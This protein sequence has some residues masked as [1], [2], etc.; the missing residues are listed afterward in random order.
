VE[1]SGERSSI[2]WYSVDSAGNL[3]TTRAS[4]VDSAGTILTTR[5]SLEIYSA[6]HR[7]YFQNAIMVLISA[8]ILLADFQ[9]TAR[10]LGDKMGII[11]RSIIM[12]IYF[13]ATYLAITCHSTGPHKG[14]SQIERSRRG[15]YRRDDASHSEPGKLNLFV[16]V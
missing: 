10:Y 14:A 13:L 3:L 15:Y 8:G 7:F 5:A 2:N 4:L 1:A 11:C 12:F 6:I 9:V 16:V